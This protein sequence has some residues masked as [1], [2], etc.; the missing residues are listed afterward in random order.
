MTQHYVYILAN[1]TNSV[2]YIGFTND[3]EHRIYAHKEKLVD[4][5]T[6]KYNCTK[7]IYFEK[8]ESYEGVLG[9][10]KQLKGW[11]RNKKERL[12]KE[13]NPEMRDLYGSL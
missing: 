6:K 3:L 13:M 9:R 8:G 11:T 10:E 12:I 5:F 1:F 2:L 7:L 4:G